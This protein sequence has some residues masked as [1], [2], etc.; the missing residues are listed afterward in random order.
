[1]A[2]ARTAH[3]RPPTPRSP[4]PAHEPAWITW[5]RAEVMA[6]AGLCFEAIVLCDRALR[7]LRRRPRRGSAAMRRG[8]LASVMECRGRCLASVAP[9]EEAELW[10]RRAARLRKE[11]GAPRPE[12]RPAAERE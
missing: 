6:E 4:G 3:T 8:L 10:I 2:P 12:A 5:L 7:S 11:I 9:P 1:M